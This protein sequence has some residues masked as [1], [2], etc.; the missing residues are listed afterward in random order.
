M[1]L[2]HSP[3]LE[4]GTK[5]RK[6]RARPR[7]RSGPVQ[8]PPVSR[9]KFRCACR[10]LR[11]PFWFLLLGC[12]F[13]VTLLRSDCLPLL[14]S[15]IPRSLRPW[16]DAP[17]YDIQAYNGHVH[18]P[19]QPN[20]DFGPT[21]AQANSSWPLESGSEPR[22]DTRSPGR[23]ITYLPHSGFNN[24]R[25]ALENAMLLAYILNCTLIA[26]PARLGAP[27]PYRPSRTL[28]LHHLISARTDP[29]EC[30]KYLDYTPPQCLGRDQFT[31][32]PWNELVNFQPIQDELGLDIQF[33][34]DAATPREFLYAL[35]LPEKSI[36]FLNDKELYEHR[37][38]DSQHSLDE[39]RSSSRYKDEWHVEYLRSFLDGSSAIHFGT[40]FGSGRLKLE[41]PEYVAARTRISRGMSIS[42]GPILEVSRAI[43]ARITEFSHNG[44]SCLAIHARVGDRKFKDTAVKNGRL[45]WWKLI[46]GL[47][48]SKEAG[49]VLEDRFLRGAGKNKQKTLLDSSFGSSIKPWH[50]TSQ[51]YYPHERCVSP[52]QDLGV[53]ATY[54]GIP[55]FIATDAAH[56]RAHPS[57]AI[58]HKTFPCTFV[59]SD[60]PDE[61]KSLHALHRQGDMSPIGR[62][63]IPLVDAVVAG[64]ATHVIGTQNSTFSQYVTSTLHTAYSISIAL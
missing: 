51:P 16:P 28:E 10:A 29:K 61:V 24:Q 35:G 48:I 18:N 40:L 31:L 63:L 42:H 56:P 34:R 60:F 37:I 21:H 11:L 46:T 23:F 12:L 20:L 1:I 19:K 47:G 5:Q 36:T 30:S 22:V 15:G 55:L 44:H 64:H 45:L 54:L 13:L 26:P 7:P 14:S 3:D 38:Y 8:N 39:V 9:K 17:N 49:R 6:I 52:H 57:L 4:A 59:L 43:H 41:R 53:E 25:I 58:F 32:I 50:N 62:F 27:L 33:I 2:P